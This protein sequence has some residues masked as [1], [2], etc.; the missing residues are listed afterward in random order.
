ML[1]QDVN[2]SD[3]NC[4]EFLLRAHSMGSA[5]LCEES[6]RASVAKTIY[7]KVLSAKWVLL[8]YTS[9][10]TEPLFRDYF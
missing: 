3:V 8:K 10:S 4:L 7:S 1:P 5:L 9:A 6:R 2:V